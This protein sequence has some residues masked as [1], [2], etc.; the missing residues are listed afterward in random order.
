MKN[1]NMNT[2]LMVLW[3]VLIAFKEN[4]DGDVMNTI[5]QSI[6]SATGLAAGLTP[7][8]PANDHSDSTASS[9]DYIYGIRQLSS[10][11][12]VSDPTIMKYINSGKL[13]PAIRRV[14]RKY[15]FQKSKIDEIF[16]KK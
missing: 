1:N 16:P 4:L 3:A 6:G 5:M 10:Y 11:L 13:D 9:T 2:L 15:T 8:A 7:F 12:G 14:G